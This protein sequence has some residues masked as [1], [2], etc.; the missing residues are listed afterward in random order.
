MAKVHGV[1]HSYIDPRLSD[2]EWYRRAYVDRGLTTTDIADKCGCSPETAREWKRKHGIESIGEYKSRGT[3]KD[4]ATWVDNT[5]TT[6]CA[7]CGESIEIRKRRIEL[8]ENN[9][10]NPGCHST[11]V[12]ENRVGENH[13]L[14]KGGPKYYGVEWRQEIRPKVRERDGHTCQFCGITESEMPRE[15]DVHHLI[16]VDDFETTADAHELHNLVCAC[17][18]CHQ[19]WEG[20]PLRPDTG[21]E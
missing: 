12:S 18:S 11:Y 9:F 6:E 3:G 16:P 20:I 21:G 19:T 17:R 5:E 13:P 1:G 2:S 7:Y 10:C 4:N 15:L 14:Y 8:A